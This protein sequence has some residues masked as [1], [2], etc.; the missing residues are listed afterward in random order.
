MKNFV[1]MLKKS[2]DI[3][4]EAPL[5]SKNVILTQKELV[6]NGYPFLPV[7]FL[8]FLQ[9][10]NGISGIDSAIL[11]VSPDGSD[12]LDIIAYNQLFNATADLVIIGYD[13]FA[14]LVYNRAQN[15]Y[16]L[17]DRDSNMVLEGYQEQELKYALNTILHAND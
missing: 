8:E 10:C 2:A 12:N 17:V 15:L 7:S 5:E 6:R 11:G 9:L 3:S 16:Q 4:I 1:S 14:F 13:D